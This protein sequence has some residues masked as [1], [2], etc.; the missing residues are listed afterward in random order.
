M[1]TLYAVTLG[2][3]SAAALLTLVRLVRG[4]SALDRVM[5]LD[6][7]VTLVVAGTAVGM[8]LRADATPVPALVVLTLLAFIGSVTAAHL[9][10][11]RE[12]M[13]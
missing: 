11:K 5:A 10:E 12:G 13:R 7:V 1:S 6:V 3:L 9:V 2:L 8:V 4:P